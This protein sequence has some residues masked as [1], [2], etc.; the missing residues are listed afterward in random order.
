MKK[1]LKI[2]GL[3]VGVLVVLMIV[4]SL[5]GESTGE[6]DTLYQIGKNGEFF[7]EK[8]FKPVDYKKQT[9]EKGD[10]LRYNNLAFMLK[11]SLLAPK[12]SMVDQYP[13]M[14]NDENLWLDED[15]ILD[16]KFEFLNLSDDNKSLVDTPFLLVNNGETI[17]EGLIH[18]KTP[19]EN[20]QKEE[21]RLIR[22]AFKAP[23]YEEPIK[24][25]EVNLVLENKEKENINIKFEVNPN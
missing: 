6:S 23:I 1:V 12:R 20:L 17:S 24:L 19:T 21:A 10:I 13:E 18:P 22:A 3:I 9:F 2:S 16:T 7:D 14:S 25:Y 5:F 15:W 4:A 8:D 11:D